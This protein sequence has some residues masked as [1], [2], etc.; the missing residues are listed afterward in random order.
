MI[1]CWLKFVV[2]L[3]WSLV[4]EIQVG[5]AY[6]CLLVSQCVEI[7][8]YDGFF[9]WVQLDLSCLSCLSSIVYDAHVKM[10]NWNLFSPC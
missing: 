6:M 3:Q 8:L 10:C 9:P 7:K 1:T 4:T 2:S 5:N